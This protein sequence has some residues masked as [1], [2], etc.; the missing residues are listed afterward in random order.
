[1]FFNYLLITGPVWF[2]MVPWCCQSREL[3]GKKPYVFIFLNL[4]NQ[5]KTL[6]EHLEN[7]ISYS[8]S[9]Y[10]YQFSKVTP[11]SSGQNPCSRQFSLK[12]H[13][14]LEWLSPSHEPIESLLNAIVYLPSFFHH[15]A[16]HHLHL[17]ANRSLLKVISTSGCERSS[18]KVSNI[19]VQSREVR[20]KYQILRFQNP[21]VNLLFLFTLLEKSCQTF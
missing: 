11:R 4:E 6:S 12:K 10:F 21:V 1:M 9:E 13:G 7:P 17:Y 18:L 20:R 19:V 3:F 14:K 2:L 8:Q 15:D 16:P 5:N